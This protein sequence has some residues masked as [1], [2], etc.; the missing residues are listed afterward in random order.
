MELASLRL[1]ALACAA[2][3]AA[4]TA[5]AYGG[6][7]SA[8]DAATLQETINQL[9]SEFFAAFNRCDL[10]AMAG[11]LAEDM[12]FF[13]DKGGLTRGRD[14]M[15]AMERERCGR[16]HTQ[17]RREVVDGSRL[18]YPMQ[19]YGAVQTGAHRFHLKE[20]EGP[21][22]LIEVAQFMHV[23]QLTDDGWRISRAISYD[24]RE[25]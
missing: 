9:D 16:T 1:R 18:V 21:E 22:L 14:R 2:L 19:G 5:P 10:P 3:I 6:E 24:H 25:P 8:P 4:T 23:W 20:G 12:E 11:F 15:I 17:L 13:H 7:A